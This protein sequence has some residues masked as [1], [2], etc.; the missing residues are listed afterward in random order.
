MAAPRLRTATGSRKWCNVASR[1]TYTPA[2]TPRRPASELVTTGA[3][4]RAVEPVAVAAMARILAGA[5]YLREP[6]YAGAVEALAVTEARLRMVDAFIADKG[7]YNRKGR[8]W[9]AVE[10]GWRLERLADGLRSS[11]G[12]TPASRARLGRQ[13]AAAEYDAARVWSGMAGGSPA[14]QPEPAGAVTVT[15]EPVGE[16]GDTVPEAPVGEPGESSGGRP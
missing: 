10:Y 7:L 8:P 16:Q 11:L 15:A 13:V 14:T 5:P 3:D 9:A 4:S 2:R 12:L 6:Q 1:R